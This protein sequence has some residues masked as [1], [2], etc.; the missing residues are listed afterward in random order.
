[1]ASTPCPL[2][3]KRKSSKAHSALPDARKCSSCG[4]LFGQGYK[5]D[6]MRLVRL[7][8]L[9]ANVTEE[10]T[11]QYFDFTVISSAGV[12]RVHG[13]FDPATKNVVQYG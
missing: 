12:D 7:G 13:W 3:G 5:G 11:E 1:M 4:A 6:L 2:C 9:Q 8:S 10:G